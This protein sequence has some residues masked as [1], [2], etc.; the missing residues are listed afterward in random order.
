MRPLVAIA[1]FLLTRVA[2]RALL[3]AFEAFQRAPE[4]PKLYPTH[5]PI[6]IRTSSQPCGAEG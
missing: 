5:S 1:L 2:K 4:P 6:P 3:V